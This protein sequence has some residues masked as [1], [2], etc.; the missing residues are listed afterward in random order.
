[1]G[2]FLFDI[3]IFHFLLRNFFKLKKIISTKMSFFSCVLSGKSK[4]KG[5]IDFG[6]GLYDILEQQQV[7]LVVA[8][9]FNLV[10]TSFTPTWT[11]VV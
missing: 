10:L 4:G 6:T 5:V 11:A 8:R 2:Q 7:G 1:M 9:E 3:E